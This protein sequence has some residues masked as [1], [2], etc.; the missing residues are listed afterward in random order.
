HDVACVLAEPAMTNVGIILP[1]PGYWSAARELTRRYGTLLIADETH[2]ICAGPGGC[3]RE[4]NLQPDIL[5]FGKPIAGGIPGPTY[6]FT[7][8]APQPI[9]PRLHL[10]DVDVGGIG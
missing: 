8:K 6:G 1:D 4:W 2:T 10:E 3:T 9:G 5:V 7:K